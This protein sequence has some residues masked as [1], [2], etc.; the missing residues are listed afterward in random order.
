[1]DYQVTIDNSTVVAGNVFNLAILTVCLVVLL[2]VLAVYIWRRLKEN[3]KL[4]YEFI[5]IIAHKFRTPLTSVKWITDGLL[6]EETDSFKKTAFENIGQ[7]NQKLIDLTSTLINMTDSDNADTAGYVM[8]RLALCDIV[9]GVV[10]SFKDAFHQKNIF[11]SANCDETEVFV[12]ADRNR[13]EF[14][15][16]TI[17]ENA[18]TYTPVGRE[19]AVSVSKSGRKAV[20]SI[21]DG[22]IGIAP[23]DLNKVFSKFFR[24]DNAKLAD[25]EG[26]GVGL[27]LAQT[28]MK[29][30]KGKIEAYSEGHNKG[31]TFSVILPLTR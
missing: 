19:V 14:V 11:F 26:F 16:Q 20:V 15:L 22:G 29:R 23:E 27:Y 7:S 30:M 31:S 24:A 1:M 9:R 28:I 13:L 6:Q 17:L 21:R 18:R 10:T 8:E 2:A 25:T 5:T 4:K 12:K 3:E